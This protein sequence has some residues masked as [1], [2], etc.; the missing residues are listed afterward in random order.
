MRRR[1]EERRRG[2]QNDFALADVFAGVVPGIVE[3][4]GEV[5]PNGVVEVGVVADG[6]VTFDVDVDVG[7]VV[8]GPAPNSIE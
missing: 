6:W 8:A 7:V 5:L 2:T 1:T 3:E 4:A